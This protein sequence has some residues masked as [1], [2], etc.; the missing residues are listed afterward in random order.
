MQTRGRIAVVDDDDSFRLALAEALRLVGYD[1][2]EFSSAEE[3]IAGD[4]IEHCD[5]VITDIR[6]RGMSGV[7][8][9]RL[10]AARATPVPVIMVTALAEPGLET[11][12]AAVGS[13]CVLKKPFG[14]DALIECLERA[15][16]S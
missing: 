6:M 16:E 15:L 8:L 14:V 13:F 7:E 12:A 3:F 11:N 5:C 4:E 10:I 2:R 1:A 9:T